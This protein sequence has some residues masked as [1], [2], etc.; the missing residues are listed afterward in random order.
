M[1]LP[2]RMIRYR[3]IHN[4]SQEE[5]AKRCGLSKQTVYAVENG[6]QE[7][8]KITREKIIIVLEGENDVEI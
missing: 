3:A 1:T 7:P 4:V 5:F 8:S 2:E 6:I